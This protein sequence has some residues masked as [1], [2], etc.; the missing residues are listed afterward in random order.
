MINYNFRD[1]LLFTVIVHCYFGFIKWSQQSHLS[2]QSHRWYFG[3]VNIASVCLFLVCSADLEETTSD[4]YSENIS[5]GCTPC[6]LFQVVSTKEVLNFPNLELTSQ[7]CLLCTSKLMIVY[8]QSR[9][10]PAWVFSF[11]LFRPKVFHQSV[12]GSFR[13]FIL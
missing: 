2:Q 5:S 13:K 10:K 11:L 6:V 7:R 3:I 1:I 9:H 12:D 4:F 8:H